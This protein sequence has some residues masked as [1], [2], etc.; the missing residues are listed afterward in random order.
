[1]YNNPFYNLIKVLESGT[2]RCIIKN[3][4]GVFTPLDKEN[5]Y[6]KEKVMEA[7]KKI[8]PM[9]QRDGGDV[10]LVSVEENVHDDAQDGH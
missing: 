7:L 6:M 10:E 1:M 2:K 5:A 8:R 4:Y 3:Q 9:L